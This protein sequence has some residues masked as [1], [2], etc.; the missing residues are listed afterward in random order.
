MLK[1]CSIYIHMYVCM[2][3]NFY[4][5]IFVCCVI[6]KFKAF[7]L[8]NKVACLNWIYVYSTHIAILASMVKKIKL[9][10]L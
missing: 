2:Y 5:N 4:R 8:P 10:F 9:K 7:C 6:K 3:I 1:F